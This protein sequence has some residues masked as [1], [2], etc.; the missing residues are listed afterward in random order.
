[1]TPKSNIFQVIKRSLISKYTTYM[2][3]LD[4]KSGILKYPMLKDVYFEK[5]K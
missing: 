1:M 3:Y 4:N 5:P 2:T